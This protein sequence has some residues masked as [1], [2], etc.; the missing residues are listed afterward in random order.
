MTSAIDFI[1]C[2]F[3]GKNGSLVDRLFVVDSEGA[4]EE[5]RNA[6]VSGNASELLNGMLARAE[7]SGSRTNLTEGVTAVQALIYEVVSKRKPVIEAR[8]VTSVKVNYQKAVAILDVM[9]VLEAN[10]GG[11]AARWARFI[12]GPPNLA[13]A[14]VHDTAGGCSYA[15]PR[16]DFR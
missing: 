14:E 3:F 8:E 12:F 1:V 7:A 5:T 2:E 6:L 15:R 10:R 13:P 9:R 4:V 11:R 16:A